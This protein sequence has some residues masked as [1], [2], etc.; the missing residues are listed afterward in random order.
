MVRPNLFTRTVQ[1]D[2]KPLFHTQ[3]SMALVKIKLCLLQQIIDTEDVILWEYIWWHCWAY[4]TPVP[5]PGHSVLPFWHL[6]TVLAQHMCGHSVNQS[7]SGNG[8][9]E[10]QVFTL[11]LRSQPRLTAFLPVHIQSFLQAAIFLINSR[12]HLRKCSVEHLICFTSSSPAPLE[13]LLH[14]G[15]LFLFISSPRL[16]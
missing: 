13:L 1:T 16:P 10:K 15:C 11:L 2:I 6:G 3:E 7:D 8:L 14:G 5:G 9:T 4:A 12:N